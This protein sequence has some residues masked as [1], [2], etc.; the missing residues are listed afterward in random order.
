MGPTVTRPLQDP[1]ALNT[2]TTNYKWDTT[3][4]HLQAQ[5]KTIFENGKIY[6]QFLQDALNTLFVKINE[7]SVA[8]AYGIDQRPSLVV[9]E[10][11]IPNVYEGDLYDSDIGNTQTYK[12]H[13]FV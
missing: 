11:G 7:A 8:E 5:T 4:Y 6:F 13:C 9:F 1:L 3:T 12:I 10:K 2:S